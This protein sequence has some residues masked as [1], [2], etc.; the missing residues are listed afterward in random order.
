[1]CI[2]IIR[3]CISLGAPS[4]GKLSSAIWGDC[5]MGRP[6]I[7]RSKWNILFQRLLMLGHSHQVCN[8]E[9]LCPQLRKHKGE[10]DGYIWES[11]SGTIYHLI[12]TFKFASTRAMF[13]IPWDADSDALC[14]S[15]KLQVCPRSFSHA[16]MNGV[17]ED[18]NASAR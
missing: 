9:P 3:R 12:R 13:R 4:T 7:F 16:S 8:I 11:H 1:M 5:C 2:N 10:D 18:T 15:A 6:G 14:H 17:L